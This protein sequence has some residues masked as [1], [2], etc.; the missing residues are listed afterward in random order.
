MELSNVDAKDAKRLENVDILVDLVRRASGTPE[1]SAQSIPGDG[2]RKLVDEVAARRLALARIGVRFG[3]TLAATQ[4][5]R[6]RERGNDEGVKL[7]TLAGRLAENGADTLDSMS[8]ALTS[9]DEALSTNSV[10]KVVPTRQLPTQTLATA[11][12][13]PGNNR[14]LRGIDQRS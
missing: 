12:L 4:A 5:E 9:L 14:R 11:G 2:L 3:S 7:S 1:K 6:L 13:N 8:E 10:G